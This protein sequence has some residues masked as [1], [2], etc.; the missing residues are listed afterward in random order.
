MTRPCK[1]YI[2][3]AFEHPT[4]KAVDKTVPQLHAEVADGVDHRAVG[5][6]LLAPVHEGDAAGDRG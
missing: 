2:A 4:R 6:E 3:G 1:A 5:P